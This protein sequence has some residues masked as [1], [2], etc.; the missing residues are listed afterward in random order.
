[1]GQSLIVGVDPHRKKNVMQLM[2]SQGQQL[3]RPLRVNNNQPGTAAFVQ[4]LVEQM[5]SGQYEAIELAS[6]AT[7]WYWF[8]FFQTLSQDPLLNQWPLELYLFN[9]RL[10]AKFKQSYGVGSRGPK[11]P[12][13]TGY[14]KT[15]F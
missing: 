5:E 3:G 15:M 1:M 2:D 4:E 6:E 14:V 12:R 7:G 8:H 10:T 11:T 13:S 9:P